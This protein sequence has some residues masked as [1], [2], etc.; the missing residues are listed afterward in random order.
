MYKNVTLDDDDYDD[1]DDVIDKNI[2]FP[3]MDQMCTTILPI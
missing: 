2:H 3:T 1:C